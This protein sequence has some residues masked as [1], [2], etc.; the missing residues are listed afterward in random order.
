[1]IESQCLASTAVSQ[2]LAG[3]N[4]NQALQGLLS[5]H[6]SLTSQQRAAAQ[7]MSYGT[8]RFYGQLRAILDLLLQ[9]PVQDAAVRAL[10]L[11]AL[12]QLQYSR[13]A[14]HA[15]VD[16][17]VRAAEALK[18]P[19][20]KGLVNA[21][22]RNFLRQRI[23]LLE[24]AAASEEGRYSHPQWWIDKLRRQYPDDWATLLETNNQHPPMTLRV[25]RRATSTAAYLDLL[26]QQGI[27]GQQVG[28]NAILLEQ[29]VSV[30]K[31]PGFGDGMASVQ[32]AGAQFAARLLD[33][34]DG[35]RVL[36]ACAAPGGKAAHLLEL[37][38]IELTALDSDPERLKKIEQTLQRLKLE[39]HCLV[40]N[41]AR[42]EEWWDGKPF[43]RILADV[44]CSASGVVR[45]HPDIKWLR[46][47][48][49]IAAFAAQQAEILDALWR[50]LGRD[51]KLL[52]ATCS[53]F[54]EEN[55]Q[56]IAQFLERHKD[57]QCLPLSL[58]AAKDGQLTPNPQHDGFYYALLLKA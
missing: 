37:A 9:K 7:D 10:L 26:H 47:E 2:V 12:Y 14:A 33:V 36:D 34:A 17:A 19:W 27:E 32:D 6:S 50:V 28:E 18:K 30:D 25:N 29:P 45:R 5:R 1:M 48:A 22:L 41:A 16:H 42:P 4:L 58:P 21:V 53:V 13:S 15:V 43:Q 56:Q 20:A 46:R 8:L 44:P 38:G 49:D 51:G 35:M 23:S 55:Q 11:V 52:Y 31:L 39:A 3:R 54:A 57:A 24:Q 40:G